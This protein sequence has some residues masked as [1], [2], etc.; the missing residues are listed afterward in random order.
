MIGFTTL[1]LI[2]RK[3]NF[4]SN[5]TSERNFTVNASGMVDG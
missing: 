4:I 2:N 1:S 3:V 5:I